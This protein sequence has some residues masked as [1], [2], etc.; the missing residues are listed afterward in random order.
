MRKRIMLATVMALLVGLLVMAPPGGA[1]QIGDQPLPFQSGSV[2]EEDDSALVRPFLLS[3][4]DKLGISVDQ[5]RDAIRAAKE[6]V[7]R[8]RL[9]EA[10]QA[11]KLAPE[12]ARALGKRLAQAEPRELVKLMLRHREAWGPWERLGPW[13]KMGMKEFKQKK[14][15]GSMWRPPQPRPTYMPPYWYPYP[16]PYN[17]VCYCYFPGW[18]PPPAPP[19]PQP[20][21]P[22]KPE[23]EPKWPKPKP[24]PEEQNLQGP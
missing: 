11:G 8:A 5:L 4:A 13:A 18:Y 21:M 3:L 19:Q 15:G 16:Y 12:R 7:I 14:L 20:P 22:W 23:P 9:E 24:K 17:C 2:L 10:V 6:E 1:L